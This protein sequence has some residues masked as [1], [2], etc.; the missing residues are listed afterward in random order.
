MISI[1]KRKNSFAVNESYIKTEEFLYNYNKYRAIAFN[2]NLNEFNR[3][4]A[5]V[6]AV[7]I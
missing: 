3:R 1:L 4:S 7:M 5:I 6:W 2:E